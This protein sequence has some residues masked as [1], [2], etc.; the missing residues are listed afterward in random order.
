MVFALVFTCLGMNNGAV[1]AQDGGTDSSTVPTEGQEVTSADVTTSV[2][3]DYYTERS[4]TAS[5]GQS[6]VDSIING[7]SKPLDG[8]DNQVVDIFPA[9]AKT[10][11]NVPA[12]SWVFGCSAVSGSMIAGYYDRT[13]YSKMYTGPSNGGVTP[14]VDTAWPTWTDSAGDP[15]PNNPLIASHNGID[16]RTT[17]GSIDDYWKYYGSSA[18]DPY[19]TGGW[20]QHSWGTAIGDYMRPAKPSITTRMDPPISLTT[21]HPQKLTCDMMATLDSGYGT[22]KV[23]DVDGTYGRKLFYQLVV[24]L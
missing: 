6:V 14:M 15:Y 4:F 21:I 22:L 17:R 5:D 16:G 18:N 1:Y 12:Y 7:P 13:G 2:I 9:T 8:Y 24:I 10:L 23:S 11:S 20:T 19:I 3:S